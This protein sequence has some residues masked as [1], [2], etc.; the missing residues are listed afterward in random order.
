MAKYYPKSKIITNQ[1]STEGISEAIEGVLVN[2]QTDIPHTGFFW[3]TANGEYWTGKTPDHLP[4]E[5]LKIQIDPLREDSLSYINNPLS[6]TKSKIA[7][8][9]GDAEPEIDGLGAQEYP[10]FDWNQTDIINYI[11]ARG[12]DIY[13]TKI[14][15]N[16]YHNPELPT[17]KDYELG[18]FTRY[19]VKNHPAKIFIEVDKEM[20]TNILSKNKKIFYYQ[21]EAITLPWTL[22]GESSKV[23]QINKDIV[24]LAVE[25]NPNLRGLQGYFKTRYLEYYGLYT[26]GGEF[27]LPNGQAYVGLYHIHPGKGPMVGRVHVPTQHDV[28]TPINQETFTTSSQNP[29]TSE[30]STSTNVQQSNIYGGTNVTPP[31]TGY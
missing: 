10:G 23:E 13:T 15:D 17:E 5:R 12:E 30:I 27:L 7:L 26:S 16:P 2:N 9:I 6:S 11:Q 19:I 29:P 21:Y 24:T 20:Y 4:K 14:Y 8:Y 3:Y 25:R 18:S 28:L 31:S 22:T 1:Y